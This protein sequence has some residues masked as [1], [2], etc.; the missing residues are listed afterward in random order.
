MSDEMDDAA[1]YRENRARLTASYL[2]GDNP[3]AQSGHSGDQDHWTQARGLIA[4]TVDRDGAFLDI[5]CANG[6]LLE[7]LVDWVSAKRYHIEPYGLDFSPELI[8]LAQKRLPQ[9]R[10]RL[11]V[12]NAIYWDPPR[13]YDFV[14]THLE[15]V[16]P[17]RQSDLI[18]R[19]LKHVVIPGGRLIIGTFNEAKTGGHDPSGELS[20]EQLIVSWGFNI[21]GRTERPH[22]RE[23]NLV[24]RVLWIDNRQR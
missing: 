23:P 1:W 9:W 16:P 24:Y 20:T 15:Y 12:G 8:E 18:G 21:S 6:F 22:F 19:L 3:R 10:D 13:R 2:A 17:K 14:R 7:C 11:F 5:G 4:D